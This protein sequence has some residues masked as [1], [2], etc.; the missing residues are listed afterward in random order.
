[1]GTGGGDMKR[2]AI[3]SLFINLA[4][5]GVVFGQ[6][7]N[8]LEIQRVVIVPPGIGLPVVVDQPDCPLQIEETRLFKYISGGGSG[9]SYKV[10]HKG[11]KPIRSYTIG[12][13][14]TGGTGWEVER[15]V[16]GN[17]VPGQVATLI[18]NEVEVVELTERLRSQLELNGEM[19]VI[20]MFM[21]LRVEYVDGSI[22]DGKPLYEALKRHLDKISE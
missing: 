2:L 16:K 5:V 19:Q 13:W 1:M 6:G 4:L 22:Y 3:C 10:R 21:V 20:V 14:N 9:Q 18:G 15:L 17:L 8:E 11:T 7:T 12:A